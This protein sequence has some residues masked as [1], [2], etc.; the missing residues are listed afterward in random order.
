MEL[1]KTVPAYLWTIWQFGKGKKI[2]LKLDQS[3]FPNPR[4]RYK[5]RWQCPIHLGTFKNFV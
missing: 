4:S 5:Q 1:F 3:Q 2:T